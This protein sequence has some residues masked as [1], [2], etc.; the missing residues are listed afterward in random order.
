MMIG[1]SHSG[2]GLTSVMVQEVKVEALPALQGTT[3][4]GGMIAPN[5]MVVA[6]APAGALGMTGAPLMKMMTTTV[7]HSHHLRWCFLLSGQGWPSLLY[8]DYKLH[9]SLILTCVYQNVLYACY[10]IRILAVN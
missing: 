1:W 8:L 3:M 5:L 2:M 6:G 4:R 10:I 7:A 9:S